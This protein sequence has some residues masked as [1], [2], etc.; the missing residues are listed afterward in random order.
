MEKGMTCIGFV[1]SYTTNGF[2]GLT[3][4]ITWCYRESLE[5]LYIIING[6]NLSIFK[7]YSC[8]EMPLLVYSHLDSSRY[9][10]IYLSK[11]SSAICFL[12]RIRCIR[13]MSINLK[14][15][16]KALFHFIRNVVKEIEIAIDKLSL[17]KM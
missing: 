4:N 10:W 9:V 17:I 7:I 11:K 2:N 6:R 13:E 16:Q 12:C 1:V 15:I 3:D 14:D 5:L 8:V